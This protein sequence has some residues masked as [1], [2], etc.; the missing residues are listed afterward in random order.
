MNYTK[1]LFSL[2][3]TLI[4]SGNI[5]S[6]DTLSAKYFPLNVGNVFYFKIE[7]R[8]PGGLIVSYNSSRILRTQ[9]Y[10]GKTYYYCTNFL[11]FGSIGDSANYYLRYDSLSGNLVRYD[12]SL[13][14]CNYESILYKLSANIGDSTGTQCLGN[15]NMKCVRIAD[16]LIFGNTIAFK[17]FRYYSYSSNGYTFIKETIF[18]KMIGGFYAFSRGGTGQS[19][20]EKKVILKGAK[21]NGV[22]Y[23]DTVL[24]VNNISNEIPEQ[25]TLSQNYPNPFNPVTNIKFDISGTSV[26]QTFGT[27]GFSVLS[28]YD[29]LG[30]EVATLVN[31][32]LK[33][34][35]Y[36]VDWDGTNYTSGVYFYKL[37]SADYAET[38][39]MILIK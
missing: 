38:K 35:T 19:F 13:P 29:I 6:L 22:I 5:F 17:K 4:L 20:Q 2:I 7:D 8:N 31:E 37:I 25:Y 24:N 27:T 12:L 36:E 16:T 10:N 1:L 26:A 23:G 33:P 32:K 28:V 30:R 15:T 34:G 21:V 3:L 14:F 11:G 9:N 18:A 39:R